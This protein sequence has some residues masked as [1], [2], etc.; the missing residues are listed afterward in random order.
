MSYKTPLRRG[1]IAIEP[2]PFTTDITYHAV[3]A[4]G[5]QSERGFPLPRMMVTIFRNRKTKDTL[6]T[7]YDFKIID[8]TMKGSAL[9]VPLM[10][11]ALAA[12]GFVP[13]HNYYGMKQ[14]QQ[15]NSLLATTTTG[16]HGVAAAYQSQFPP[17]LSVFDRWKRS[18]R[19][20]L[21]TAPI[22]AD[23]FGLMGTITMQDLLGKEQRTDEIEVSDFYIFWRLQHLYGYMD[24]Y[25]SYN[26]DAN[27]PFII[28]RGQF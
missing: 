17:P 25:I 14:Q 28:D 12:H 18:A 6:K 24:I 13:G 15:H 26:I 1:I 20:W 9:I 19:F 7:R 5:D 10:T 2:K 22:V 16:A 21:A 23:Y 8:T 3:M 4:L 11:M 27:V